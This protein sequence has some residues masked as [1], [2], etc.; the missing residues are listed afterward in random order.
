[1]SRTG[2]IAW[3]PKAVREQ[4][5]RRIEDGEPG[6]RLAGWLNAQP[7]VRAVLAA[8]FG[9]RAINEQNLTEWKQGGH[10]DW[11]AQQ[12]ALAA[13]RQIKDDADELQ[14]AGSEALTERLAVLAAA[15]LAVALRRMPGGEA[16]EAGPK[17]RELCEDIAKLRQGDQRAMQL[18]LERE[19]LELAREA[20]RNL[21]NEELLAWAVEHRSQLCEGFR[22]H[23]DNLDLIYETM[24]GEP[25]CAGADGGKAPSGNAADVPGIKPCVSGKSEDLAVVSQAGET[26]LIERTATAGK[27]PCRTCREGG[28]VTESNQI[29]PNQVH[30]GKSSGAGPR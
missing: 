8:E 2:K 13:L 1:M 24:F 17:L 23:C 7:E 19:R 4:L 6:K 25:R 10:L 18:R 11:L 14:P 27:D 15:R 9:G 20:E 3:L 21:T 30:D 26:P 12:E 29:K 22:T 5:N 16:A 28:V